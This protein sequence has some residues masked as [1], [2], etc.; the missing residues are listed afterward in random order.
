MYYVNTG[1]LQAELA[2][3]NWGLAELADIW[4]VNRDTAADCLTRPQQI[5]CRRMLLLQQAAGWSGAQA[6]RIFFARES[7]C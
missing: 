6:A 7:G 1:A 5:S 3:R 4:Q 2:R